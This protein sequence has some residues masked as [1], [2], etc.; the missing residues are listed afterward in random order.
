MMCSTLAIGCLAMF[1]IVSILVFGPIAWAAVSLI[2]WW[3]IPGRVFSP[4]EIAIVATRYAMQFEDRAL[5]QVGID[6]H[7]ERVTNGITHRY[8]FLREV[9]GLLVQRQINAG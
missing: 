4:E 9:S 8:R 2:W 7:Q 1:V 5:S 3:L 6:M